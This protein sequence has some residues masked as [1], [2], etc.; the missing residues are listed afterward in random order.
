MLSEYYKNRWFQINRETQEKTSNNLDAY[1]KKFERL[2][3][4]VK[5][6]V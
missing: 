1:I 4:I 3:I 2:F 5:I 6:Q